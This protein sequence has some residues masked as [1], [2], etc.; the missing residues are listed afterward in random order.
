MY[1]YLVAMTILTEQRMWVTNNV[2]YFLFKYVM[3]THITLMV[4]SCLTESTIQ[5]FS[6]VQISASTEMRVLAQSQKF[7]QTSNWTNFSFSVR[8]VYISFIVTY[9]PSS[10]LG[11]MS[12]HLFISMVIG[13]EGGT[14]GFSEKKI[15]IEEKEV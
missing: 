2:I 13:G 10:S 7:K 15:K 5:V 9:T 14:L 8:Y 12:V 3:N 4:I 11:C 6:E 1:G